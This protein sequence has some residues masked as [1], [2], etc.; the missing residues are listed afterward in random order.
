[1]KSKCW[2]V[3]GVLLIASSC[4]GGAPVG[5]SEMVSISGTWETSQ[6]LPKATEWCAKYGKVPRFNTR[7]AYA[8][9][10]DCVKAS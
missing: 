4:S 6:S 2:P 7:D 5:N 3:V 9:H 8:M 1:M 10:Y